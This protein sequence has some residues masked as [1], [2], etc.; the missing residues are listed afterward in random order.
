M[1]EVVRH[2]FFLK[3]FYNLENAEDYYFYT[4]YNNIYK[5]LL[6]RKLAKNSY[7]TFTFNLNVY[8]K[9][10]FFPL[11]TKDEKKKMFKIIT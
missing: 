8:L 4:N 3:L 6:I 5:S 11:V 10:F 2:K 7:T 1:Y 9:M